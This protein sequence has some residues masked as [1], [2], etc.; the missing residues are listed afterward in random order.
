MEIKQKTLADKNF[1]IG[2]EF[3]AVRLLLKDEH[4]AATYSEHLHPS[5]FREQLKPIVEIGLKYWKEYGKLPSDEVLV[6]ELKFKDIVKFTPEKQ[7]VFLK[8]LEEISKSPQAAEYTAHKINSF[9]RM[10]RMENAVAASLKILDAVDKSKDV[11]L[12]DQ[13]VFD[14]N[15]ASEPLEFNRP[16]FFIGDLEK[17][18]DYREKVALG[19][20]NKEGIQIGIPGI[21]K[22][23][24]YN[25]LEPSQLGIWLAPTGRGKSIALKHCSYAAAVRGKKVVFFSLELPEQMLLD[26][27]DAMVSGVPI[28]EIVVERN[29]V[30]EEIESITAALNF[31]EIVF[32]EIPYGSTV[33]TLGNELSRLKRIYNF[34]PDEIV[35]DYLDLMS[36][37]RHIKEGTWKEQQEVARELKAFGTKH[38]KVIWTASQTN[39]GA[40]NKIEEGGTISDAD[41]AESYSKQTVADLIISLNQTKAEKALPDDPK[42]MRLFVVKNRTG[43]AGVTKHILTAF[44]SMCFYMGEYEPE[45]KEKKAL[46]SGAFV[47]K[48]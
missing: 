28:A 48:K 25:G 39:R 23:L 2:T 45:E 9:I 34:D 26:R 38:K 24:P 13:I 20:I 30:K 11:K 18:T 31:G 44:S 12:L 8:T 47:D 17:R 29:K 22:L 27:I 5:L 35:V 14:I 7:Q 3:D 41:T 40:V 16:A 19:E 21:D 4:F 15:K 32:I 36:S 42:P 10:Q 46:E 37:G 6:Q 43:L 33:I 1:E